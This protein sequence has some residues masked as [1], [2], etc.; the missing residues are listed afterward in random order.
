MA[1]ATTKG[2][3]P[4]AK[5]PRGKAEKPAPP[6]GPQLEAHQ[7]VI[8]PLVT[9]KGTHLVERHNTYP[10]QVHTLATKAQIKAAVE[11]LF[12]VTVVGVRTQSRKGKKRRYRTR[13]GVGSAWKKALVTLS[14]NDRISMF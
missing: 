3:R 7:V 12:E 6:K 10:F 11:Q 8:R 13:I 1:D 4:A 14:E 5:A 9:E 2:K